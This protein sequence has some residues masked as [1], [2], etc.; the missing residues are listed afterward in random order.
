MMEE[1]RKG[2]EEECQAEL[3]EGAKTGRRGERANFRDELRPVW[4][5]P[6]DELTGLH[7]IQLR[8]R[9]T[10]TRMRL[11]LF[12]YV[13]SRRILTSS[14]EHSTITPTMKFRIPA[15]RGTIHQHSEARSPKADEEAESAYR[16][17]AR[18][19]ELSIESGSASPRSEVRCT[20]REA[21]STGYQLGSRY[22]SSWDGEL[23][24]V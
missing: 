4:R 21:R 1:K 17:A 16:L 8:R 2:V 7:R 10:W 19:G 24:F 23:T 12:R 18:L 5:G 15:H 13:L 11:S 6:Q 20:R 9:L 3:S 22:R 14:D